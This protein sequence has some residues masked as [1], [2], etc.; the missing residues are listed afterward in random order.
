MSKKKFISGN[1]DQELIDE[2]RYYKIRLQALSIKMPYE[3]QIT[4]ETPIEECL[5]STRL[6]N[7]LLKKMNLKI[8]ADIL[9]FTEHDFRKEPG[10]GAKTIKELLVFLGENDLKLK[11]YHD[12]LSSK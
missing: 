5:F 4:P 1:C 11:H 10:L 6:E 3:Q 7:L 9:N 8:V 2:I 12:I